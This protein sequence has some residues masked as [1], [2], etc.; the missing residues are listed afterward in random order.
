NEAANIA[1]VLTVLKE[2]PEI[3]EIIVVNDGSLDETGRIARQCGVQ[4]IDFL[5]NQGK[6]AAIK[7]GA[8]AARGD[9]LL[10][11]DADLTGLTVFHVQ[12]LVRPV[13]WQEEEAT[14]GIFE[15]GRHSTDWAQALAPF[16]S[17]QRALR[18]YILDT[19]GPIDEAGFGVELQIHRH[20]KRCGTQ[21][22]VVL[23][24]DVSQVMK[25]EKLGLAK[26]F[27]A[28]MKMYWE[29]IRELPRL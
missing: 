26:G 23:L 20:M 13:L 28:R 19:V 3:D 6:G 9:I 29:I 21:P 14:V 25:E 16:L 4:V 18:R 1:S 10:F 22:R 11:L 24:N 2:T 8:D 27:A 17:G 15:G 7:A 12:Q 5:V